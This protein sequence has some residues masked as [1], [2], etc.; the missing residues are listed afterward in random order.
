MK[1]HFESVKVDW[2]VVGKILLALLLI[3]GLVLVAARSISP[4]ADSLHVLLFVAGGAACFLVVVSLSIVVSGAFN[5]W[6]LNHGATDAQWFIFP[7]SQE[8]PGLESLQGQAISEPAGGHDI[9]AST[10][11]AAVGSDQ[12]APR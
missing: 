12:P 8:P 11:N 5:Q 4:G 1:M 3:S 2:I 9:S 6:A 10:A 7:R